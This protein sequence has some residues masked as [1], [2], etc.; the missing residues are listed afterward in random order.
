[1]EEFVQKFRKA[2]RKSR[3][4][5]RPLIEEFKR[6]INSIIKTL[7]NS[8]REQQIW[9]V[10]RGDSSQRRQISYQNN[11]CNL[12]EEKSLVVL[13]QA[14]TVISLLYLVE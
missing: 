7:R 1:M 13:D 6:S 3:Y 8:M 12:K 9:I 11:N 2:A 10:T 14:F 4:G 5:E